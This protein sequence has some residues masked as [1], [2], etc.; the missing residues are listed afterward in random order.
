MFWLYGYK[1]AQGHLVKTKITR[2][3]GSTADQFTNM[4]CKLRWSSSIVYPPHAIPLMEQPAAT[5]SSLDICSI[6]WDGK[7]GPALNGYFTTGDGIYQVL[8][9]ELE[10][11]H[12]WNSTTFLYSL[13]KVPAVDNK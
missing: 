1:P 10:S 12:R 13:P 5:L 9:R 8:Y 3:G 6:T 7:I 4:G 2:V 11:R